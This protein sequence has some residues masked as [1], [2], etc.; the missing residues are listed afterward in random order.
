M[1]KGKIWCRR[2]DL[3][4]RPPHYECGALPLSYDGALR[5]SYPEKVSGEYGK[6]GRFSSP[7]MRQNPD[8][9]EDAEEQ[10]QLDLGLAVENDLLVMPGKEP[11][12][13]GG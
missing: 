4:L 2:E 10:E 8:A 11:A 5:E 7:G 1:N 9:R 6:R 3:N 12:E 13:R